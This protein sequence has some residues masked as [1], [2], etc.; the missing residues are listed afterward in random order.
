VEFWRTDDWREYLLNEG[1]TGYPLRFIRRGDEL[2]TPE[3]RWPE[4]AKQAIIYMGQENGIKRIQ[5]DTLVRGWLDISGWTWIIN[6]FKTDLT[7]GHSSAIKKAFKAGLTCRPTADMDRF[8][9]TYSRIAGKQTR[10][11]G[12]FDLLERWISLG[13]GTLP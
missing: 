10:P 7:K 4:E 6:P 3:P 1:G 11:D 9:H 8:K 13:W 2:Y 12:C 5:A